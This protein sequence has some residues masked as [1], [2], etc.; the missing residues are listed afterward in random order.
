MKSS[1]KSSKQRCW[2][3]STSRPTRVSLVN[4][5]KAPGSESSRASYSCALIRPPSSGR[6]SVD[7]DAAHDAPFRVVRDREVLDAAVVPEGHGS[8]LPVEA[9]LEVGRP[10]MVEEEREQH[11][12]LA[13]GDTDEVRRGIA[14]DEERPAAGL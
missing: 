3:A 8:D 13:V 4:K 2:N 7:R 11:L 5:P 10:H 9:A 12:V 1:P 6:G 14:V